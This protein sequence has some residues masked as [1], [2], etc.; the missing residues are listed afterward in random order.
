[1]NKNQIQADMVDSIPE[2][3]KKYDHRIFMLH[4]SSKITFVIAFLSWTFFFTTNSP[5]V[6]N[7]NMKPLSSN[8][9]S[10]N[11]NS[12]KHNKQSLVSLPLRNPINRTL[13]V[14]SN[15]ITS[16]YCHPVSIDFYV[17]GPYKRYHKKFTRS[18][19]TFVFI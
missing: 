1:M 13:Q 15:K 12:Q 10:I 11:S 4:S 16:I 14:F 18:F 3:D 8:E 6:L 19:N 7:I 5:L 2:L 9:N 17:T